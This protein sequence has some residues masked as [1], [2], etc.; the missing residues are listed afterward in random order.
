MEPDPP[1]VPYSDV[2]LRSATSIF[3]EWVPGWCNGP[4]IEIT[5]IYWSVNKSPWSLKESIDDPVAKNWTIGNLQTGTNYQFKVRCMNR[6]GWSDFGPATDYIKTNDIAAPR[7]LKATNRGVSF[8]TLAWEPP[9][10]DMLIDRYEIQ[11][12]LGG[13]D[14]WESLETQPK[15]C[16]HLVEALLPQ[17]K[18]RFRVRGFTVDGWSAFTDPTDYS[19]TE[20][21]F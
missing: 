18:Y 11:V 21:R 19:Q 6:L 3:L 20:R 15:R 4:E 2:N 1:S 17:H 13:A 5:E 7:N 8:I 16:H 14:I 10:P 12:Q 9:D